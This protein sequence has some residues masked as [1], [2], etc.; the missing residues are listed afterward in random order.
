MTCM[1]SGSENSPEQDAMLAPVALFVYNR[2]DHTRRVIER[3]KQCRGFEQ[4][5]LFVFSDGPA[6]ER[7]E[8]SVAQVRDL[9]RRTLGGRVHLKAADRNLGLARS[10]IKG[11]SQLC[12]THGRVIVLEDDLS[13]IHI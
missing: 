11:V 10:I 6:T 2:P 12:D 5:P 1:P 4:S 7:D 8:E 3:L 9:I 13:L